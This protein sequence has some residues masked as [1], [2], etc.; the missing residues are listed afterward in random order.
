ME[1]FKNY[2]NLKKR[3]LNDSN[4]DDEACVE[5]STELIY[6]NYNH[7]YFSGAITPKS[8]FL[9]CKNLRILENFYNR[10]WLYYFGV[11]NN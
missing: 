6:N 5:N 3:K 1:L 9:L 8:S 2:K 4:S 11:F 10:W 7:L